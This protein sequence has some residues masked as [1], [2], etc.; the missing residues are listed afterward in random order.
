MATSCCAAKEALFEAV[1][2]AAC[3]TEF[4]QSTS[5]CMKASSAFIMSTAPNADHRPAYEHGLAQGTVR[6]YYDYFHHIDAWWA[7]IAPPSPGRA[8]LVRGEELCS[9]DALADSEF[10]AEFLVPNGIRHMRSL[11]VTPE[12][13]HAAPFIVSWHRGADQEPFGEHEEEIIRELGPV[14]IQAERFGTELV[15]AR[16]DNDDSGDE[17]E[18]AMFVLGAGGRLLQANADGARLIEQGMFTDAGGPLRPASAEATGWL[19]AHLDTG[20]IAS[21]FRPLLDGEPF[22]NGGR[23]ADGARVLRPSTRLTARLGQAGREVD[24][25]LEMRALGRSRGIISLTGAAA[26]LIVRPARNADSAS[27]AARTSKLFGWTPTE[28]DTV[29]RLYQNASTQQIS[30]ARNC[31]V[32]TVRTHLKHAKRKAGVRRQVE[33][34]TLL[35]R[36]ETAPA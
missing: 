2:D 4:L 19:R 18:P 26:L 9:A 29:W 14:L 15:R 35:M 12:A 23:H 3:W 11:V 33:L 17:G 27:L 16:L 22:A 1:L 32:E 31:S 25:L 20:T 5:R 8:R 6:R 30:R 10:F 24:H 13:P 28:F 7:R 21:G 34:V 36:L